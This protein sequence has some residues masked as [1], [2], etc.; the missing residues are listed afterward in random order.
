MIVALVLV[1]LG[2][3]SGL[4][5]Y[6]F[7]PGP[8]GTATSLTPLMCGEFVDMKLKFKLPAKE[9]VTTQTTTSA[10]VTTTTMTTTTGMTAVLQFSA[11]CL[12]VN[13][14]GKLGFGDS[15][16]ILTDFGLCGYLVLL[17]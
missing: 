17:W 10:T 16:R 1:V 15:T 2:P 13:C 8:V 14:H 7:G 11:A 5:A 4:K 12:H 3:M 6:A 9:T